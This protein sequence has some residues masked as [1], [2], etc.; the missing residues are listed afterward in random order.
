[1]GL[2]SQ[3]ARGLEMMLL[4]RTAQPGNGEKLRLAIEQL[5]DAQSESVQELVDGLNRQG[6]SVLARGRA[7]LEALSDDEWDALVNE[8]DDAG[9]E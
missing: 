5:P 9:A 8:T 2:D 4:A 6:R 3:A 7:A 1:M